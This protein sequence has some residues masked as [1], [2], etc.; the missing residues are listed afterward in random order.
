LTV[1]GQIG[2]AFPAPSEEEREAALYQRSVKRKPT[3]PEAQLSLDFGLER[4]SPR[5]GLSPT[6]GEGGRQAGAAASVAPG[7]SVFAPE[8]TKKGY[9]GH[10]SIGDVIITPFRAYE[11]DAI[12]EK[13]RTLGGAA[14]DG[15]G[16][17]TTVS[18]DKR[19][20]YILPRPGGETRRLL[21]AIGSEAF[22][23]CPDGAGVK[24]KAYLHTASSFPRFPQFAA[25]LWLREGLVVVVNE[26]KG[27]T[28][29]PYNK[30]EREEIVRLA[31]RGATFLK[32]GGGKDLLSDK[33]TR[34]SQIEFVKTHF[35]DV[36]AAMERAIKEAPEL[37]DEMEKVH[38]ERRRGTESGG[39][40]GAAR[41]FAVGPFVLSAENTPE[42]FFRNV[43]GVASVEEGYKDNP[44]EAA[45]ALLRASPVEERAAIVAYLQTPGGAGPEET[46]RR[47]QDEYERFKSGR[48]GLK[49]AEAKEE[50]EASV[51]M[52]GAA[53]EASNPV[54]ADGGIREAEG[55]SAAGVE[56][57][58][59]A[60][61]FRPYGAW[62]DYG[63]RLTPGQRERLNAR[64]EE[65]LAKEPPSMAEAEKE[66]LRRYSGFGGLRADGERG[67]IYDFYTSPPVAAMTWRLLE[68]AGG[69]LPEGARV[70]EPSCGTGVFFE[71]APAGVSLTGVDLDPR[72]A[73]VASALHGGESGDRQH[74]LRTVQPVREKR[75]LRRGR[76]QRPLRRADG[77]D[78]FYGH[79]EGKLA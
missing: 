22:F 32:G 57:R 43:N 30:S 41:V 16:E 67:V 65:I 53:L 58:G 68:K 40:E 64:A 77:R 19:G 74:E 79:A 26:Y 15:S 8:T 45:R 75:R 71:T 23:D 66:V 1:Y 47:I 5:E 59:E 69:K 12:H 20:H 42:N 14:L 38:V 76:R 37:F 31:G 63:V 52:G 18:L 51:D 36:Y 72:A 56:S 48:A 25:E 2:A 6:E 35:P 54:G 73:A 39:G 13:E 34:R 61:H 78:F 21:L 60:A 4:E 24:E 33:E 55:Q 70:L 29:N 27:K 7:A 49:T 62:T 10:A 44:V 50:A 9:E 3:K 17:R 28:L 11:I 46:R